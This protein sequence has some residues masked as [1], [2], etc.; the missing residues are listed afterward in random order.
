VAREGNI[1]FKGA[2][3]TVKPDSDLLVG[4]CVP[5]AQDKL[6]EKLIRATGLD[7]KHF[8]PVDI[9]GTDNKGDCGSFGQRC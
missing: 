9:R 2:V 3:K 4:A 6:F 8:V 5:R 7:D 1:I